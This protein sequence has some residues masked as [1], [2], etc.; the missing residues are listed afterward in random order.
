MLALRSGTSKVSTLDRCSITVSPSVLVVP[1]SIVCVNAISSIDLLDCNL[2][3]LRL[4]IPVLLR[5][6]HILGVKVQRRGLPFLA[7]AIPL[8]FNLS[9]WILADS[10][11]PTSVSLRAG[12]FACV[13]ITFACLA[14]SAIL[15]IRGG[16]AELVVSR[17]CGCLSH[18]M[19]QVGRICNVV[20]GSLRTILYLVGVVERRAMV[21]ATEQSTKRVF[22]HGECPSLVCF[23]H[24]HYLLTSL[25]AAVDRYS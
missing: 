10:P 12:T 4:H 9:G 24:S 3:S 7:P 15:L 21:E 1:A 11:L 14:R 2:M 19:L 6:I 8:V 23:L 5:V 16:I 13:V 22:I 25:H 17:H 18:K 20:V